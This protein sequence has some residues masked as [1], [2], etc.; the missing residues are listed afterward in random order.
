V[1]EFGERWRTT[2]P[3]AP[4][5]FWLVYNFARDA[6]VLDEELQVT[7][8]RTRPLKWKSSQP[9]PVVSEEGDRR[10]FTWKRSQLE[11][12]SAEE[13][14]KDRERYVKYRY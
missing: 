10:I 9:T 7:V 11:R 4:G 2:C 6:I 1:L 5:Q 12:K 13:E 8:P 14:K 3:L